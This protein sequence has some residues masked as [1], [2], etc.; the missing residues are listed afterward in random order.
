FGTVVL[1]GCGREAAMKRQ[2]S[3]TDSLAGAIKTVVAQLRDI[4]TL[5]LEN[6]ISRYKI[7]V[8]F[9]S[10]HVRDTT[11]RDESTDLQRL[12]VSGR[13]LQAFSTNRGLLLGRAGALS[14]QLQ[15]LKA[16]I[17]SCAGD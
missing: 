4:D 17:P 10:E 15:T 14:V 11:S 3:V 9:I 7:C 8:D 6:M 13:Q 12:S 5:D 2:E 1:A 16:D